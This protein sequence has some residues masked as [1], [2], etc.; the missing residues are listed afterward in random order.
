MTD[1]GWT[2]RRSLLFS[3]IIRER[4]DMNQ[5]VNL[6][7]YAG[8][9]D[10]KPIEDLMISASAWEHLKEIGVSPELVFAHPRILQSHPKTSMHYRGIALL[11]RKRVQQAATSVTKWEDGTHNTPIPE[12]VALAVSR[13]YNTIISSI[14]EDSTDWSLENGYRN[15]LAT[16]GITLDGMFRNKIGD[17]AENLIKTKLIA[18]LLKHQLTPD[19]EPQDGVYRLPN[20]TFMRHGSEPDI[21]FTR[22]ENLIA[23]IEV[24]GGTD[25][26][27]AL[28]RLG[29]MTKSFEET[30]PSCVNFLVAGVVTPEMQIRLDSIGVV[31]VFLLD[32]ITNDEHKWEEFMKEV[33]HYALR[34]T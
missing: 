28:E 15:I 30:P 1:D 2:R 33:F 18:W 3:K 31:K 20:Q 32:E 25:P 4:E 14:I 29:A 27:G 34:L 17:V 22:G 12:R 19:D 6:R 7:Q 10:Y 11:S 21:S 26:G 5:S 13:F 9:F 23:T 8:K 24:K 16:M